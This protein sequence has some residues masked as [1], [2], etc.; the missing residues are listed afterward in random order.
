VSNE[1]LKRETGWAPRYSSRET[2]EITM[3]AHGKL[4]DA[5]PAAAV[6]TPAAAA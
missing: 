6:P 4:A 5:G 3:R 1:K 2:F